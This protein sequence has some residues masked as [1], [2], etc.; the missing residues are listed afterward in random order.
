MRAMQA[1]TAMELGLHG[2]LRRHW[3]KAEILTVSALA[4]TLKAYMNIHPC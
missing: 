3:P 4:E 1:M 2:Q